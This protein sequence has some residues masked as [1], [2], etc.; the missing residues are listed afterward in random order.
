VSDYHVVLYVQKK[1]YVIII[2]KVK[3]SDVF[4]LLGY[5]R[6]IKNVKVNSTLKRFQSQSF[7]VDGQPFLYLLL[8]GT[9]W[10]SFFTDS[11]T[12][13]LVN[14]RII[15]GFSI[16]H[17]RSYIEHDLT[18]I[19]IVKETCICVV[20]KVYFI[21]LKIRTDVNAWIRYF[22]L[23]VLEITLFSSILFWLNILSRLE[24]PIFITYTA[25]LRKFNLKV[26]LEIVIKWDSLPRKFYDL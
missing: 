4:D 21:S 6:P 10:V 5:R 11:P 16:V 15:Y 22:D 24:N 17:A 19:H 26:P 18:I 20:L 3:G 13:G 9:N 12:R 23:R 25:P 1:V 7:L 2:V 14:F 8:A